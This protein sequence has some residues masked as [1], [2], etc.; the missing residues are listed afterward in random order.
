MHSAPHTLRWTMAALATAVLAA[1]PFISH[2]EGHGFKIVVNEDCPAQSLTRDQVSRLFLGKEAEWPGGVRALPVDQREGSPVREA[3]TRA[4]HH[5]SVSAVKL[6]WQ[7]A[8]FSGRGLPPPEASG[9]AAVL[10][11][12]KSQ[13]GAIGY[14]SATTPT[15]GVVVATPGE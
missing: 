11:H 10:A 5:R 3:F 4:I 15:D 2:A 7:Q 14:V 9:D 8:I 12:V 13:P 6:H 1:A